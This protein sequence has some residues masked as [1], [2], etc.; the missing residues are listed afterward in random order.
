[1]KK[2]IILIYII[3]PYKIVNSILYRVVWSITW[4]WINKLWCDSY[5]KNILAYLDAAYVMSLV[6][7]F[8]RKLVIRLYYYYVVILQ[9]FHPRGLQVYIPHTAE[10]ILVCIK[11]IGPNKNWA[12]S[13]L[14]PT[15]CVEWWNSTP[16]FILLLLFFFIKSTRLD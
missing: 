13:E 10:L 5:Q 15:L 16:R 4:R 12:K 14:S 3:C 11:K 6:Y 9:R 2:L 8:C 1:M 7:M